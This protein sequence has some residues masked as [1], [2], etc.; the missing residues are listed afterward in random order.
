MYVNTY[1]HI[2]EF[3]N[4]N[5][6]VNMVS[7]R[8]SNS[9]FDEKRSEKFP[10]TLGIISIMITRLACQIMIPRITGTEQKLLWKF[11]MYMELSK[12]NIQA[13]NLLGNNPDNL[14]LA[15][16]SFQ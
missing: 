11:W 16:C 6:K 4:R 8:I 10:P 15:L 2:Y 14:V 13:D 12:L 5:I 1:W 7:F 9:Y 3:T